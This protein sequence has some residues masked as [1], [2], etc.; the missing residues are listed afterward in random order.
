[1]K[2]AAGGSP[3]QPLGKALRIRRVAK[4]R[5]GEL[6]GF[7][8]RQTGQSKALALVAQHDQTGGV[9]WIAPHPFRYDDQERIL[10]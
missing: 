2:G 4:K 5:P 3:V 8:G 1:M 10:G 7:A 6:V 9:S